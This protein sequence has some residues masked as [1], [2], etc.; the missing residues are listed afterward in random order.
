M[1]SQ[2]INQFQSLSIN[3]NHN[4]NQKYHD[5]SDNMNSNKN[6]GYKNIYSSSVIHPTLLNPQS[7]FI[8]K[9]NKVIYIQ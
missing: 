1:F 6:Y 9:N 3:D 2:I 5:S 8:I 4:S 7:K